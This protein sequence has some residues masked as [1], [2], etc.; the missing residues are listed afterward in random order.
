MKLFLPSLSAS[1]AIALASHALA[2]VV[3]GFKVTT[4]ADFGVADYVYRVSESDFNFKRSLAKAP[5]NQWAH[6]SDLSRVKTQQVIREN[7]DGVYS[8]AV[9]GPGQGTG[10]AASA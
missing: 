1:L 4:P 7:Q 5:V 6:Q 9:V 10:R 3:P 8:S 2:D